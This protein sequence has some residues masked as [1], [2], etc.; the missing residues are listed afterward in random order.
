MGDI[1]DHTAFP[2]CQYRISHA[3]IAV[4]RRIGEG[5]KQWV[6]YITLAQTLY[7]F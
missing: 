2:C 1:E 4:A 7:H 3:A 6:K 5:A